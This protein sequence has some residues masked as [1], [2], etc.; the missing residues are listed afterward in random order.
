M[1]K[2]NLKDC[3]EAIETALSALRETA[4][5]DTKSSVAHLIVCRSLEMYCGCLLGSFAS[6]VAKSERE[7]E[8]EIEK[9]LSSFEPQVLKICNQMGHLRRRDIDL[10]VQHSLENLR[11]CALSEYLRLT[12]VHFPRDEDRPEFPSAG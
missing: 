11:R 9:L 5:A 7:A 1:E 6:Y 4:D 8:E 12:G 2:K 10:Q 3:V